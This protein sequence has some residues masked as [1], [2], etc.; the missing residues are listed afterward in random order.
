[1]D[2]GT[3]LAGQEEEWNTGS[4]VSGSPGR[5]WKCGG[6]AS[7]RHGGCR[8]GG[9]W[10]GG[11]SA[12][13]RRREEVGDGRGAFIGARGRRRGVARVTAVLMALTSL[14]TGAR[15]RGGLRGGSDGGA[16]MARA[17]SRGAEQAEWGA[18]AQWNSV[19]TRPWLAGAG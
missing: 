17:A 5:G 2:G 9:A 3:G 12:R 1:V 16:V 13:D 4:S 8:G 7:R 10:W 18:V 6:R 19:A 15:L 11:V 14:K